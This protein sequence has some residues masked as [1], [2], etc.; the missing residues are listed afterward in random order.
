MVD[1]CDPNKEIN[2]TER[3]IVFYKYRYIYR[4]CI[5]TFRASR[6][7]GNLG[8]RF[9][10]FKVLFDMGVWQ[11]LAM[12]YL[13]FHLGPPFPI[14]LRPAGGSPLKRPYGRLLLLRTPHAVRPCL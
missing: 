9:L 2:I 13:K 12:D 4:Q 3:V 8:I 5:K 7:D 11:G 1:M 6:I 14:L 10:M